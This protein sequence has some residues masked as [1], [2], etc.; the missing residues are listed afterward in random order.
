MVIWAKFELVNYFIKFAHKT[1]KT[2]VGDLWKD[3]AFP[4]DPFLLEW[5]FGGK[6]AVQN[7]QGVQDGSPDPVINGG[8]KPLEMALWIGFPA[9]KKPYVWRLFHPIYNYLEPQITKF[10]IKNIISYVKI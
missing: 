4:E 10:K 3:D 9:V 1:A 7:F 2:P 8:W 6:L 5:L